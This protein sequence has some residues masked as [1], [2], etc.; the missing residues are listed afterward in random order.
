M[1]SATRRSTVGMATVGVLGPSHRS[2]LTSLPLG[3]ASWRMPPERLLLGH[4]GPRSIAA[5][6]GHSALIF[7]PT[8]SGKTSRLVVPSVHRWP[9]PCIVTSVKDDVVSA[10]LAA[11]RRMGPVAIV[12]PTAAIGGDVRW[13]SPV[14][15]ATSFEAARRIARDLCASSS[16]GRPSADGAFWLQAAARH[17]AP[18]LRA[19]HLAGGGIVEVL[20]WLNPEMVFEAQ[21]VLEAFGEHA[22]SSVLELGRSRDER[23]VSSIVTTAEVVL[24]VF[25]D[26]HVAPAQRLDLGALLAAQGTLYLCAP[27]RD[28]ARYRGLLA[29]V[30][31]A[32]IECAI[33]LAA[34]G[35]IERCLVVLD[36]GAHIAAL[37]ELD[38]LAAT[39][40]GLG[41]SL[42]TVFQDYGQVLA[43]YG[44]RAP[45]IV[46]NHRA[47]LILSGTIDPATSALLAD[48]GGMERVQVESRSAAQGQRLSVTRS[49]ERMAVLRPEVLR[50]VRPGR[51]LLLYGAA[52]PCLVRLP[53]PL[54]RAETELG[55]GSSSPARARPG[56]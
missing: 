49:S 54:Q 1:S 17:L 36:E 53:R 16:E 29:A 43:R 8:Q 12:E 11:R 26:H 21:H 51:G 50:S 45:S 20:R 35:T 27:S 40:V 30:R 33:E 46:A 56:A 18:L 22:A 2:G 7:G 9:G 24:D 4:R 31:A 34:S 23:Q 25:T 48:I 15:G 42:L 28:Q 5:E 41:V 14:D 39:G 19:A 55:T 44:E 32:A 52:P 38:V 3:T 13:W 47:R 6:T 10:T 37:D